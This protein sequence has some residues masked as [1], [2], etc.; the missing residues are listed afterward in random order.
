[1]PAVTTRTAPL[2]EPNWYRHLP[3]GRDVHLLHEGVV[4][5]TGN[6]AVHQILAHPAVVAEHPLKASS[7]ALGP[8]VLDAD[9]PQHRAFRALLAP[10]LSAGRID[11]YARTLMPRLIDDLTEELAGVRTNEFDARYA[12]RIPYG[13]VCAVLGIDTAL[14]ERFHTL[15]RPLAQLLDYPTVE[16]PQTHRCAA[17][18]LD[19][20]E[21][22]RIARDGSGTSL[23]ETIERTRDRKAITLS[24]SEVRSTAVLFF[25]AGTETSSAYITSLVY[26]IGRTVF[27]LEELLDSEVRAHFLEEV[28]RLYPPV[29]TVVRFA[30]ED[31]TLDGVTVPR[32]SA[33]LAS[34]AA[35][36][37]DPRVF[38]YPDRLVIGRDTKR[39][40]PFAVGAHACPGAVLAKTEFGLLTAR[41]AERFREIAVVGDER[42]I[43][44]QSFSHPVDFTVH[45]RVK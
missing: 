8:N 17:E 5:V 32:H 1:M 24:D 30:A 40:A 7:R 36:N 4:A 37:R 34:I 15:T 41:L 13:L 14:E 26:C 25:I 23:L 33:I 9:G 10:V 35:A 6:D 2:T 43:E 16:T 38:A 39:S 28:L 27:G 20:I 19:L 44:S 18:L 29:Q 11:D 12:H 45:F 22:Q 21:E 31:I 3:A 42:R